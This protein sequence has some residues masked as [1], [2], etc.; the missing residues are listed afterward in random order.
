MK[1]KDVLRLLRISRNT[2]HRYAENGTIKFSKL[3]S[4]FYNYDEEDVYKILNKDIIRK[5]YIYARV[6]TPKQK[7]DL[8]NQ[9]EMLKVWSFNTG[10]R[11]NGIY[12]D[13]ASGISFDKRKDFFILLDEVIDHKVERVIVAYKDRLS[14]VGF[15]LFSHLFKQYG[16]E[17]VVVSEVGNK[18]LDS[19][20]IFEEIISLLHCYSMKLYSKRQNNKKLEVGVKDDPDTN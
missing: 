10:I 7:K 14:R 15:E 11:L 19:E 20:E 18:K 17:I 3:P 9:I 8:E 6:S 5:N 4:G 1:A 13:I 16:T 2:L 12:S